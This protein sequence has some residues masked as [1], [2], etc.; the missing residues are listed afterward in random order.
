MWP[1]PPQI[2]LMVVTVGRIQ[3]AIDETNNIMLFDALT[4]VQQ[5]IDQFIEFSRKE[6][7]K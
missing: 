7:R 5:K 2:W 1:I 4:A 6:K 3:R